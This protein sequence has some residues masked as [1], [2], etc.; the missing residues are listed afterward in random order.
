MNKIDK[1]KQ[2]YEFM[3]KSFNICADE[4]EK[5]ETLN[6]SERIL[7]NENRIRC[8]QIM[9]FCNKF[10]SGLSEIESEAQRQTDLLIHCIQLSYRK[11]W[12]GDES[13]G[14]SEL[15]D[16]MANTM[17]DVMGDEAFCKW[18]EQT[19]ADIDSEAVPRDV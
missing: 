2:H 8:H 5:M 16:T 12:M 14:W 19:R 11:H 15:G 6:D 4:F 10:V 17:A 9:R 1:L 13:I 3:K 18:I 7:I